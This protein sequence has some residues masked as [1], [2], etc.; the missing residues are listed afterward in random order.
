MSVGVDVGVGKAGPVS[1]G[2]KVGG[3]IYYKPPETG[4]PEGQDYNPNQ[5]ALGE[6]GVQANVKAGVGVKAPGDLSIRGEAK[7]ST[8]SAVLDVILRS[9][10]AM[11][12]YYRGE[13]VHPLPGGTDEVPED[14]LR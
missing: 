2:V 4:T 14:A 10:P 3:D 13:F 1:A 12:E 5:G 8:P 9:G 11:N 7:A 6:V